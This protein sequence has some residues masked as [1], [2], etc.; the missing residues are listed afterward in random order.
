MA[1]AVMCT[2]MT[3]PNRLARINRLQIRRAK[4]RE[5]ERSSVTQKIIV[6]WIWNG[7][8]S[9]GGGRIRPTNTQHKLKF[10]GIKS[11]VRCCLD[12]L[13]SQFKRFRLAYARK[14]IWKSISLPANHTHKIP[15]RPTIAEFIS[16][17]LIW[18]D[19]SIL[20]FF[21]FAYAIELCRFESTIWFVSL[22]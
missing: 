18:C 6:F 10:G 21:R 22:E 20:I 3:G 19:H 12:D 7:M 11:C 5:G 14:C 13:V 9:G 17:N 2:M 16:T 1:I 15:L 4:E 8:S